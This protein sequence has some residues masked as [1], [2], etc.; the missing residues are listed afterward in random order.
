MEIRDLIC[1][2]W[3]KRAHAFF[4]VRLFLHRCESRNHRRPA[5]RIDARNVTPVATATPQAGCYFLLGSL[6]GDEQTSIEIPYVGGETQ[7]D[8]NGKTII[9]GA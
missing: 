8:N 6:I 9:G 7:A 3:S 5:N 4:E 2:T 1:D